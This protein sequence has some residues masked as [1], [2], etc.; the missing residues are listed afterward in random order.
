MVAWIPKHSEE[1]QVSTELL[2]G[3]DF[4]R[5]KISRKLCRRR[6]P[7][8]PLHPS[9]SIKIQISNINI[10]TCLLGQSVK[11]FT[12]ISRR[13]SGSVTTRDGR[14]D[15]NTLDPRQNFSFTKCVYIVIR[16]MYAYLNG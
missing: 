8:Q 4:Q 16:H 13:R 12:M 9:P 10:Y 2:R 6:K 3:E 7:T 1:N 5:R 15:R 11:F 14:R